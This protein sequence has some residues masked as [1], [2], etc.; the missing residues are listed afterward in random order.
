MTDTL[1]I[2]PEMV[3]KYVR[4]RGGGKA[5]LAGVIH[6][7]ICLEF[8]LSESFF[9]LGIINDS[10]AKDL[11]WSENGRYLN[12]WASEHAYDIISLWVEEEQEDNP[13]LEQAFKRIESL[14]DFQKSMT[15]SDYYPVAWRSQMEA[16]TKRI[17]ELEE[18]FEKLTSALSDGL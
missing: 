8:G 9:I 16:V 13:L 17:K 2:T 10:V 18:L 11:S 15:P 14:E 5:Y 7:N 12:F 3:G 4:L 6:K 1:T